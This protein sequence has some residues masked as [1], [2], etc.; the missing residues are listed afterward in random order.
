MTLGHEGPSR[1]PN[2]VAHTRKIFMQI[3]R[4]YI[5]EFSI[6]AICDTRRT[7]QQARA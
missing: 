1:Q 5:F 3:A 2:G 4:S 6:V 7:L